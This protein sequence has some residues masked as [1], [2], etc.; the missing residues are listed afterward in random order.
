MDVPREGEEEMENEERR[1]TWR[2]RRFRMRRG[3]EGD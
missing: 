3:G 1:R 2:T